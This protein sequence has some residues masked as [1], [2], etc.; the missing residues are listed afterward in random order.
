MSSSQP[1]SFLYSFSKFGHQHSF[2][3]SSVSITITRAEL[4]NDQLVDFAIWLLFYRIHRNDFR[5]N[6]LLC[7]G[8]S[9]SNTS[10]KN[11]KVD[12]AVHGVH[13][14]TSNYPN[15]LVNTLKNDP[16]TNVLDLLGKDGEPIMLDI[17]LDCA[18]FVGVQSGKGNLYQ[19]SGTSRFEL[20]KGRIFK[21]NASY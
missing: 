10:Q 6:H 15:S 19:L 12:G 2:H 20:S 3:L 16:W 5:P 14:V 8:Y 7:H 21:P 13:G 17:L 1:C 18:I 11:Y 9:R 4:K